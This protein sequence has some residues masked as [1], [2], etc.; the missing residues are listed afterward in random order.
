MRVSSWLSGVVAI[1]A[2]TAAPGSALAQRADDRVW[3]QL[4]AFFPKIDSDIRIDA[5]DE[6]LGTE[7]DLE[8][9][10]GFKNSTTVFNGVLGYQFARRWHVEAEYF[11][12]GRKSTA[13]IDREII[14]DDTVYPVNA[15][16]SG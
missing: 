13:T 2:L 14:I 11:N 3:L 7:I 8:S 10:L 4:G 9:D 6:Q 5:S 12:V 16:L 1:A 15:E